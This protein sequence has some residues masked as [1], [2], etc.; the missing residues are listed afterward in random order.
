MSA[1]SFSGMSSTTTTQKALLLESKQGKFVVGSRDIPKPG[2][3]E[4]LVKVLATGLNPVDW[5]IQKYGIFVTEFP[6]VLGT[7]LAGTVEVV[8]EGVTSFKKGD[9]VFAQGTFDSNFASFQQYALT[10]AATTAKIPMK[11]SY[12]DVATIPVALTAAYVG[13]YNTKPYGLQLARPTESA[14]HGKYA[15][16]PIIVLGGSSSVGQ[17]VIELAKLSG[18]S[19]IIAT[20]SLKHTEFLKSLGATHV[21]DRNLATDMLKTE[22]KKLTT[23]P[24]DIVYDA[25]SL[26]TTQQTGNDLLVPGGSLVT[27]L[28]LAITKNKFVGHT[29]VYGILRLPQNKELLEGLYAKLTHY[30]E[31]GMIIPNRVQ[32]LAGGLEGIVEGLKEM[33]NDRVSGVKLVVRPWET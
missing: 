19:P 2:P 23:M 17:F 21:L 28:N 25:I 5:K 22:I 12:E 13:L 16:K 29:Q 30:L 20:A 4:L 26:A 24:I 11:F 27:V 18:F 3:G 6:A 31:Q 14:N 9:R 15:G 1:Y 8:G 10:Y 33:E 7:D 32:L